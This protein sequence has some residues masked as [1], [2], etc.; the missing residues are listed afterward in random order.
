M[1]LVVTVDGVDVTSVVRSDTVR[2]CPG[3]EGFSNDGANA[4]LV[5]ST[6]GPGSRRTIAGRSIG[7]Y[8]FDLILRQSLPSQGLRLTAEGRLLQSIS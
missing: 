5:E 6:V 4:G 8:W 1:D 3:L 7:T 2:H